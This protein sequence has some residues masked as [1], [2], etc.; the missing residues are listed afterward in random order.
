[1]AEAA[2]GALHFCQISP[3]IGL[4]LLT[5]HR[6]RDARHDLVQ[7]LQLL[8]RKPFARKVTPVTLPPGRPD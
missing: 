3:R 7:H 5:G 6:R 8:C 1:M 2:R 4:V